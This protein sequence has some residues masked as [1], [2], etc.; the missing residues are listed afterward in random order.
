MNSVVSVDPFR[1]RMWELHD[2][3]E[4]HISAES[5]RS[6]ID[7]FERHGQLV[8]ALG[9]PLKY[10]PEFDVELVCGARR[11]FVARHLKKA[12]LVDLR[13]L[14]DREAIVS[15]DIEN[16][17]RADVSPYERGLSYA[18]WLR[19]GYFRSQDDIA[20]ALKISASQVSRYLKLSRLPSVI[21]SAFDN[22]AGIREGWG[23]ELIEILEDPARRYAVIRAA[24]AI[25]S[26][27]PRP[28]ARDVYRELNAA[29]VEGR[30]AK[31]RKRDEVIKDQLGRPLFRIRS[32]TRS[33]ALLI[34][35]ER[36]SSLVLERIRHG[37]RDILQSAMLQVDESAGY[38][39]AGVISEATRNS[40]DEAVRPVRIT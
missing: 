25:A 7:S 20:R 1:C 2:R 34:P 14:T 26:S 13:E 4:G 10:V 33:T 16:R 38:N 21:V 15:I 3:L 9:R 39:G 5:C 19:A 6:E 24:R 32:Q 35:S 29:A 12:L 27:S 28:N 23:L 36:I 8:P 18:Q 31:V 17:Q 22:P 30:R 37:V 11:L 40:S